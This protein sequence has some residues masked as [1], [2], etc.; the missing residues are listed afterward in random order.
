MVPGFYLKYA[1]FFILE[2]VLG[3]EWPPVFRGSKNMAGD[4]VSCTYLKNNFFGIM[5]LGFYL[6]YAVFEF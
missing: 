6:K 4:K 1:V 5:V 2:V 3:L